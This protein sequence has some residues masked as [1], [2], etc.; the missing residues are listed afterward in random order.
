MW[1]GGRRRERERSRSW[2]SG[3]TVEEGE[4]GW[5][6][7]RDQMQGKR[8]PADVIKLNGIKPITFQPAWV[9]LPPGSGVWG[10]CCRGRGGGR[11]RHHQHCLP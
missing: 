5:G 4:R 11:V 1:R 7:A 3:R 10:L 6:E 9:P 8:S 2:C